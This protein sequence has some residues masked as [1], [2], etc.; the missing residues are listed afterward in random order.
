[1]STPPVNILVADDHELLREGIKS[2]LEKHPGW[3]VCAEAADGREAVELALRLRPDVVV[4]DIGMKE[5]NGLDAARQIHKAAPEMRVLILTMQESETMIGDALA[6]G[7]HG[8]ILKTDAARLLPMAVEA[9]LAQKTFFP[10]VVTDMLLTG[11]LNASVTAGKNGG[12]LT[13]RERE[14]VQ[15]LAES[16]TSKEIALRL[17]VSVKTIEAHRANIMR[18]LKLHS[19]ADLVRYAI[20]NRI[21]EA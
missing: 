16:R 2:R 7:V 15:L 17:G 1:M 21:A 5:L 20:R 8:Y 19:V 11:F 4:M 6:A 13:S 18:K 9:L 14:I 12:Q 10:S 3:K